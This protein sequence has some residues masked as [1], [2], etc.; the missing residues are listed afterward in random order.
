MTKKERRLD[1]LF[2][3]NRQPLRKDRCDP[4]EIEEA[5]APLLRAIEGLAAKLDA[6]IAKGA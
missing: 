6:L 1:N 4:A 3:F 5:L 2:S